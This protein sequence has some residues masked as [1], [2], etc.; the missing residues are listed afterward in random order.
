MLFVGSS[1]LTYVVDTGLDTFKEKG[2]C[3]SR[4][5]RWQ[6]VLTSIAGTN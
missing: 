5:V 6:P 1:A 2:Y 3:V 4:S